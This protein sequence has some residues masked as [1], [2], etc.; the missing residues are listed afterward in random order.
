MSVDSDASRY[1]ECR[2]WFPRH[3]LSQL[4]V[5]AERSD[6]LETG[7]ILLGYRDEAGGE[8]V[9]TAMVGPGRDA[10]HR[11]RSFVPDHSFHE[12]EVA[13]LYTESGRTWSYLGDWHT[14][15]GGPL[16]LSLKDQRTLTRIARARTA[17]VAHPVMVLL[18]SGAPMAAIA[19]GADAID[20]GAWR[21]GAWVLR[22]ASSFWSAWR[23]RVLATRCTV[24]H[25]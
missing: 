11:R 1:D 13:R 6:P 21:I 9:V 7:G 8:I 12:R 14:H 5:E 3:V 4:Q 17:R 20:V 23:V 15:P 2:V 10:R 22:D 19:P 16:S 18:A 24:V 25:F